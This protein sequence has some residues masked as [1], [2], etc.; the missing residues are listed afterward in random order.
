MSLAPYHV[1]L[2]PIKYEG[3]VKEATDKLYEELTTSG[4]E[5]LVDDRS[6][7]PGVKFMDADLIGIPYRV[8]IGDKNLAGESPKVE[9]KRRTE[10]EARLVEL[11][12][13][14]G[15]LTEKVQA[16]LSELS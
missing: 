10:K 7:R 11:A 5:V 3:A 9:V 15:E 12:A 6:E 2:I 1:I 16:E 14:A 8:V 4:I 13:A